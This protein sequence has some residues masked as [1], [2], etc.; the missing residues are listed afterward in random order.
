[1]MSHIAATTSTIDGP[2]S[3]TAA[4]VAQRPE[5]APTIDRIQLQ[6]TEQQQ[7]QFSVQL[8]QHYQ[9]TMQQI[10]SITTMQPLT[11]STAIV[12]LTLSAPALRTRFVTPATSTTA[13]P[14]VTTNIA[15]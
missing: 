5:P 1:M 9:A 13:E 7:Q 15:S 8:Q 3:I 2:F 10:S 14:D 4:A 11:P 6:T 12:Y